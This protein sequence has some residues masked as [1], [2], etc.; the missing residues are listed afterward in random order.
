[1]EA[2][3]KSKTED[4]SE[5]QLESQRKERRLGLGRVLMKGERW[6]K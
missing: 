2:K 6:E 3:W 1:M 4:G 5:K